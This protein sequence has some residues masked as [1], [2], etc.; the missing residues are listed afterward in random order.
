MREL[1]NEAFNYGNISLTREVL[2]RFVESPEVRQLLPEALQERQRRAD[3]AEVRDLM[4]G[5][6]KHFIANVYKIKG[7]GLFGRGRR[8]DVARNAMGAGLAQLLPPSLFENKHGRKACRILGI[9]YRQAKQGVALGVAALDCGSWRQVKTAAHFDNASS[10]VSAAVN[11]WFHSDEASEPWNPKHEM[12]RVDLGRDEKGVPIYTLHPRRAQKRSTRRSLP[13]FRRSSIADRL[14]EGKRTKPVYKN[15]K[16]IRKGRGGV[17]VGWR[18]FREAKCACIKKRKTEE[19]VCLKCSYLISNLARL[20]HDRKAWHRSARQRVGG[21][22]C[23]CHIH[24]PEGAA[25]AAAER[26]A[27][28]QS[29]EEAE[30]AAAEA[31]GDGAAERWAAA[32]SESEAAQLDATAAAR[33]EALARKYDNMTSSVEA[34]DTQ[35]TP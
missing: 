22:P 32:L 8:S 31:G 25:E 9:S 29:V 23:V 33:K 16:M 6:A 35:H 4:L 2:R 15:G 21:K 27:A 7:G 30:R 20:H 1:R 3:D 11:E 26:A 28:C 34:R 24:P 12:V 14:R 19:C 18:Q 17:K 10:A 5:T 13:I